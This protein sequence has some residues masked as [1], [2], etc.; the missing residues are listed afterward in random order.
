MALGI[1]GAYGGLNK[2]EIND[3][4]FVGELFYSMAASTYLA[5]E[6]GFDSPLRVCYVRGV[7]RGSRCMLEEVFHGRQFRHFDLSRCSPYPFR[8]GYPLSD[9]LFGDCCPPP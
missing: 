2:K 4:L 9:S 3:A 7:S 8:F 5:G 1:L 6:A